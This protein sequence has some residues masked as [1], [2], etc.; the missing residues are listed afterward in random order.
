MIDFL[1]DALEDFFDFIGEI[2]STIINGVISFFQHIVGWFKGLNLKK[3][4]DVPFV[5]DAQS[6]KFK[7]MLKQAPKKDVGIF[8]GV[9]NEDTNEITHYKYLEGDEIDAK[10]QDLLG[11]EE[12]VVL[13]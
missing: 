1:F 5:A 13:E 12:L 7:Q 11:D 4:R 2:V 6:E 10:T 3:G 8:E 9:Y